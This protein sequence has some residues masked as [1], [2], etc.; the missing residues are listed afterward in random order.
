MRAGRSVLTLIVAAAAAAPAYAATNVSVGPAGEEANDNSW[1]GP[2]A[3]SADGRYVT[4]ASAASNLA[5][6]DTNGSEDMFVHDRRSGATERIGG[7]RAP[8]ISADGRTLAYAVG[9]RDACTRVQL[10]GRAGG[11]AR[12]VPLGERDGADPSLD[13]RDF[14]LSPDGRFVAS[15]VARPAFGK[16]CAEAA[17]DPDDH[18]G[19][20]PAVLELFDRR[21]GRTRAIPTVGLEISSHEGLALSAGGRVAV[22][23]DDQVEPTTGDRT[24]R[25]FAIDTRS[26]RRTR[27]NLDSREREVPHDLAWWPDISADGRHVA[28]ATTGRLVR[29]DSGR[30]SDV[31]VRDLRRGR[32]RRASVGNGG[33]GIGGAYPSISRHGRFVAFLDGDGFA[34]S[35][36]H[37]RD[38]ARRRTRLLT[39]G[40]E[41]APPSIAANG[42]G[43]AFTS[44]RNGDLPHSSFGLAEVFVSGPPH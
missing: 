20:G 31:Y 14:R 28:F 42:R 6:G 15:L 30:D 19:H 34:I 38:M 22:V 35:Q 4:F 1:S 39:P 18:P 26:G 9:E 36:V 3:I 7:G 10:R 23:V 13:V 32:T 44:Y 5:S 11:A 2:D 41:G 8:A 25:L 12:L 16:S 21:T 33:A 27:V 17:N 37:V 40:W 24:T 29:G 43:V